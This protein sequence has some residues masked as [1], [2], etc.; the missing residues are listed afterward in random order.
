MHKTFWFK[1]HW[2]LVLFWDLLFFI[3]GVSGAIIL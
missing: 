3:N 1:I 2:F